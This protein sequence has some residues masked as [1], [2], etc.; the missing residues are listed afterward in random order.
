MGCNIKKRSLDTIHAGGILTL[1]AAA[2]EAAGRTA[3][4]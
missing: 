2:P 3:N 4:A 1:Y